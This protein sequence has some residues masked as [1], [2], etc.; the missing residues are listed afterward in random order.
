[1]NKK[2]L[3]LIF[4]FVVSTVGV[5]ALTNAAIDDNKVEVTINF[6]PSAY[7]DKGYCWV[8]FD[9]RFIDDNFVFGENDDIYFAFS[10]DVALEAWFGAVAPGG[11]N[12]ND[13]WFYA[14]Q[15]NWTAGYTGDVLYNETRFAGWIDV[16]LDGYGLGT[17]NFDIAADDGTYQ[18]I[19]IQLDI[20][21][22]Y[23][24]I[25]AAE[26]VSDGNHTEWFWE[27][28][29]DAKKFYVGENRD[30]IPPVSVKAYFNEV[31]VTATAMNSEDLPSQGY[32]ITEFLDNPRPVAEANFTTQIQTV[33]E[34][35]N[36]T[37][38]TT[39]VEAYFNA[40]DV[41]LNL[42]DAGAVVYDN[43]Y[44]MGPMTNMWIVN[45]NVGVI[46]NGSAY[47][48]VD[49]VFYNTTSASYENDL[50][51]ISW[52][53][54]LPGLNIGQ[55]YVYFVLYGMAVDDLAMWWTDGAVPA[56]RVLAD[57][58]IFYIWI[59]DLPEST[60]LGFGIFISVSILGLAAALY[61]VR[62]RK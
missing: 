44:E 17:S 27:Y 1:M 39:T 57:V 14:E 60:G 42:A 3:I 50:G 12:Q 7:I 55:N 58:A 59:G 11:G 18:K 19:A 62:R 33:E 36:V 32:N 15:N 10:Y 46:W 8:E 37:T 34:G 35:D 41:N 56:P 61:F 16:I 48:S 2:G 47:I 38:V 4:L 13:V 52:D 5:V 20:G 6:I 9:Q 45:D 22:H 53:N 23:L 54:T 25:S 40:S 28:S 31:D 26:L 30:V 29:H 43:V 21:W 49:N 51:V 24:T